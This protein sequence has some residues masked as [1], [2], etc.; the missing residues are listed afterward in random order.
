MK[1]I[2]PL[3]NEAF[4][5]AA[6]IGMLRDTYHFERDMWGDCPSHDEKVLRT[7]IK[8]SLSPKKVSSGCYRTAVIFDTIVVKYP[9]DGRIREMR[10]E[11][12]YIQRMM[13]TE[14]ARHF[15]LTQYVEIGDT[16]VLI[17][18][19]INMSHRGI[20]WELQ[21]A[22]EDLAERHLGIYDMHQ[23]NYGWKGPKGREWPVF[24]DVDLRNAGA[25][26]R[27]RPPR[28]SWMV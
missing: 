11:Y 27:N 8:N 22:A 20:S 2:T 24:V 12:E 10:A 15:P 28:R 26:I 7:V 13:E 23:Q 3:S 14:Y 16:A 5:V 25:S 17:Q 19:K 4:E 6:T 18:E 21:S 9:R 1:K